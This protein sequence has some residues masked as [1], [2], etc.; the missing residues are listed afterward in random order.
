MHSITYSDDAEA[1]RA[2]F[3]DV[4]GWPFL[5]AHGG[6][7][8][9]RTPP[10]EMGVHPTLSDDGAT[11]WATPPHHQLSLMCD[12]VQATIAELRAKGV[13][14]SGDVEDQ[15]FGLVTTIQVP[16][17]GEMMLYE[18]RHEPAHSLPD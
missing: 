7:L 12:D 5:D 9:F 13:E 8:I 1:T 3:R 6:W 15:G 2:F 17:A 16:G 11:R 4:L 14:V 18:P 10:G